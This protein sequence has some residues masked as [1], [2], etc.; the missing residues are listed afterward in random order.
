[1]NVFVLC[2]L[3]TLQLAKCNI[4]DNLKLMNLLAGFND[5]SMAL[6]L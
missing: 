3:F 4:I 1:M 5:I 2:Y 6:P